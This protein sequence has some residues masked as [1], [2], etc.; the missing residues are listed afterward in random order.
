V[1]NWLRWLPENASSYGGEIDAGIGLIWAKVNREL[2]AGDLTIRG[3][4]KQF[5]SRGGY[6][7]RARL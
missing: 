4:A 7:R 5:N 1:L 3:T 2:P 6:W